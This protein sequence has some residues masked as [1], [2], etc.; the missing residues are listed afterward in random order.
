MS[1]SQADPSRPSEPEL[2]RLSKARPPSGDLDY[3]KFAPKKAGVAPANT[4]HYDTSK[5]LTQ[6]REEDPWPDEDAFQ[7]P[8]AINIRIDSCTIT[9]L[10]ANLAF[11]KPVSVEA[12]I[13]ILNPPDDLTVRL[14]LQFGPSATGPWTDLK[15][16]VSHQITAAPAAQTFTL[17]LELSTPVQIPPAKPP[18]P[19]SGQDVYYRAVASNNQA[20]TVESGPVKI[21]Y[22]RLTE[23]VGS[24]DVS[25][26]DHSFVPALGAD[27]VF[28][29]A[30]AAFLAK[31]AARPP[32]TADKAVAFG[33]SHQE[34]DIKSNRK[35]SLQR[36]E[37]LKSLLDRD[38][39]L[40]EKHF[41]EV[42]IKDRQQIL[43][44][45]KTAFGWTCDPGAVNGTDGA[46]L[47][48][49]ILGFQKEYNTRFAPNPKDPKLPEKGKWEKNTW[50]GLHRAL[51]S[52]VAK[53]LDAAFADPAKPAWQIPDWHYPKGKG[54]YPNGADFPPPTRSAEVNLFH[55]SDAPTL[56]QPTDKAALTIAE[57]P[58]EDPVKF[59]KEP[60]PIAAVGVAATV[61]RSRAEIVIETYDPTEEV[62]ESK[63]NKKRIERSGDAVEIRQWVN[64][65]TK[66]SGRDGKGTK[67]KLRIRSADSLRDEAGAKALPN[68]VF[69]K[70]IFSADGGPANRSPR[71]DKD[72]KFGLVT[73]ANLAAIVAPGAPSL[74]R[75]A[76][77]GW[78]TVPA[79]P[80]EYTATINTNG[81]KTAEIEI[82]LG[83]CGGDT[84]E[85]QV[86]STNACGD[87]KVRFVNW[88]RLDYELMVPECQQSIMNTANPARWDFGN[89]L[90][91]F[92]Q[93]RLGA[94]FVAYEPKATHVYTKAQADAKQWVTSAYLLQAG[95]E[96]RVVRAWKWPG[97]KGVSFGA[98]DKR[99]IRMYTSDLLVN[100]TPTTFTSP[101]QQTDQV[102]TVVDN[103]DL[104]LDPGS[105]HINLMLPQYPGQSKPS[106]SVKGFKWKALV[107]VAGVAAAT[108][109]L[110]MVD[111]DEATLGGNEFRLDLFQPDGTTV[112][113]THTVK[114][115]SGDQTLS[116]AGD[117][118]CVQTIQAALVA[119]FVY[120]CALKSNI[121][122]RFKAGTPDAATRLLAVRTKLDAEYNARRVA[123]SYHPGLSSKGAALQGNLD[124]KWFSH[125][126]INQ[127]KMDLP[128]RANANAPFL[129]GDIVGAL[130]GTNCPIEWQVKISST[131][132][133]NGS[134]LNGTQEMALR[135]N[136]GPLS[137]T[138]CH[139]LGHDMGLSPFRNGAQDECGLAP[140]MPEPGHVD[141]VPPGMPYLDCKVFKLLPGNGL[142]DIHRGPHCSTGL[143]AIQRA[144]DR[145]GGGQGSCI[146][147]GSSHAGD[148]DGRTGYC[149]V[150]ML[151]L[152]SRTLKDLRTTWSARF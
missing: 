113:S 54:A 28:I 147:F 83:L 132:E 59:K 7:R 24:P 137:S 69:L 80:W 142:R 14:R 65:T 125:P 76:G 43:S 10:P 9:T 75:A 141:S 149:D 130:S 97:P 12:K 50:K 90:K 128:K 45:L 63:D 106:I 107:N 133:L 151:Q 66:D 55:P 8:S 77:G 95:P 19:A 124:Q 104:I 35:L 39:K 100:Y 98:A 42:T 108:P 27:G 139:E 36:A 13:T 101:L 118:V 102:T 91:K 105:K 138:L 84:C 152:K 23:Y 120:R 15:E 131:N 73:T 78:Q 22:V 126:N 46:D 62:S 41:A 32:K 144:D 30:L 1:N 11:D 127:V 148:A 68:Q 114:F 40:W 49:G 48:A 61:D 109:T 47:E 85:V 70:V 71:S 60:I 5:Y 6:L 3:S 18:F 87:A 44:D 129:P 82:D 51:C 122:I 25:F 88:R 26:P 117:A 112:A 96:D 67:L 145:L 110:T 38:S 17:E 33:F 37:I 57:N 121:R 93:D 150:C 56:G 99:T 86:G 72:N 4:A 21:K 81:K 31:V 134:A 135:R 2:M 143:T 29:R 119:D 52:L 123:V 20:T 116:K 64:L 89:A 115:A 94:G 16:V 140:G 53:S 111:V 136:S 92:L 74:A 58:V 103:A 146:M 34:A 79:A